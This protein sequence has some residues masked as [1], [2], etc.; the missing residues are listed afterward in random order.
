MELENQLAEVETQKELARA[1]INAIQQR[2]SELKGSTAEKFSGEDSPRVKQLRQQLDRLENE[3]L[4]AVANNPNSSR[5]SRLENQ[6]DQAKNDMIQAILESSRIGQ[7]EQS[8]MMDSELMVDIQKDLI[9]EEL[10]MYRMQ[11][12]ERY[13]EQL[14]NKY[15]RQHPEM[16][17]ST[18]ELSRL[19]RTRKVYENLYNFLVERGEEANIK[20]AT[21]TGGIRIIDQPKLPKRPIPVPAK[22]NIAMGALLGLALG[23]GLAFTLDYFD[24][25]IRN[26]E[27]LHQTTHLPILATVQT[28]DKK[29]KKVRPGK[30]IPQ[31]GM[32]GQYGQKL[33]TSISPRDPVTD[34][35]RGLR[36]NLQFAS[37]DEPIKKLL[38]TSP[39]PGEG[40][41]LTCSN[42]GIIFSELGK[43]VLIVDADLRKPMQH[44]VF[45]LEMKPGLTEILA[46]DVPFSQSIRKTDLPNLYVLTSGT[47]PPNPAE[48]ISSEKMNQLLDQATKMFDLVLVD[49][50]PV[51]VVTDPVLLAAKIKNVAMVVRFGE[52][53]IK[54]LQNARDTLQRARAT[55]HG[56]ILNDVHFSR[57]YG[58][59]SKYAYYS[60]YYAAEKS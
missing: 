15:K 25:S 9:Q 21:S 17:E 13:Y 24:N 30:K 8:G 44:S 29:Q 6:I 31:N 16:L 56:L 18:L 37:A 23:V 27:Q 1:N 42:L 46:R 12:R 53:D 47:R 28:M 41:T 19:Q 38:V 39:N 5:V 54:A 11:N 32:N 43:K 35:Y 26:P 36:T 22:R 51:N 2:L 58:Y 50:P 45:H 4:E 49:S 34:Q 48:M 60:A 20:A 55:I 57:A 7:S 3:R 52:T 10:T 40:K 14:I 33:L 59:Y